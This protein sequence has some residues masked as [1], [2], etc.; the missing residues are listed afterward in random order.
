[1]KGEEALMRQL[2]NAF[3][4]STL[5]LTATAGFAEDGVIELRTIAEKQVQVLQPDGSVETLLVPAAKV[6]PGDVVA[7]T[8]EARNISKTPAT[9]VVIT[10]PIPEHMRFVHGSTEAAG[11]KILFSVDGG[12]R[13]DVAQALEVVAE[14][15]TRRT[16]TAADYTHIRFVFDEPLAPTSKRSVRFLAQLQ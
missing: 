8:I 4:V 5:L 14:D 1:M 3:L 10:D 11:S 9:R 2:R 6:V 12:M 15:G 13:F 16:A 7:Y